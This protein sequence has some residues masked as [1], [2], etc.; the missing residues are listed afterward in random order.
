MKLT[1]S[2]HPDLPLP[3]TNAPEP[4]PE[5][6][7]A[8]VD[9]LPLASERHEQGLAVL[10]AML[11]HWLGTSGLSHEQMVAIASWGIGE[12][13]VIDGTV[14]SR[15]RNG[16]QAR[17]AALRHLDGI[18]AAN[19]AIW[20]WQTKGQREAWKELG[21]QGG[22]GV[23]EEWLN[24]ATWLPHP[25][26]PDEPLCFADL[27]E[28]S[29]GYLELPYLASYALSPA[30][31]KRMSDALVALLER[32]IAERGWGPREGIRQ[33]LEVYPVQESARRRRL[34]DVITGE[35]QYSKDELETEMAALAETLRQIRQLKPGELGP[36]ELRDELRSA[37]RPAAL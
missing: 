4:A 26:H 32:T 34:R 33:V 21:P 22:W 10:A 12:R 19:K 24:D 31:A 28:I 7:P 37:P 23:R 8:L 35:H 2:A 30:A 3:S 9:A 27:A 15:V 20:L 5:S 29:A 17:G 11:N 6:G 1:V 18:A 13:G 16:K 25:D 36:R 14:L